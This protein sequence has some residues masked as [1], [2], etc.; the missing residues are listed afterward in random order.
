MTGGVPERLW[1]PPP[2][3]LERSEMAELARAVGAADYDELWRW[4]V[5]VLDAFWAVTLL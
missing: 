5:D 4:S 1:S 3:L 2:D